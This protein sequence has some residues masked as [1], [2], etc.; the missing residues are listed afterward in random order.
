ML[1]D[2]RHRYGLTDIRM[3]SG[4]EVVLTAD[5]MLLELRVKGKA[6]PLQARSGPEGSRN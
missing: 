1:I 4:A 5:Y 3:C 2:D 6:V